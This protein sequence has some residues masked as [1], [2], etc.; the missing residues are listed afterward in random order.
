MKCQKEY[1]IY[2]KK[3]DNAIIV[4]FADKRVRVREGERE[5]GEKKRS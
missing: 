3:R 5:G 1:V 2:E 4:K